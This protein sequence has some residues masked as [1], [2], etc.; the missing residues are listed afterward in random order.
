MWFV[1][2]QSWRMGLVLSILLVVA[3]AQEIRLVDDSDLSISYTG[4][5]KDVPGKHL[6]GGSVKLTQ[7]ENATASL[8][9]NGMS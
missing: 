1:V 8:L 2:V 3:C 9:F 5:W 7:Q 6:V 4:D